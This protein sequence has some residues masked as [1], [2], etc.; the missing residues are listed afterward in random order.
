[1]SKQKTTNK[2]QSLSPENYIRQRSKNLPVGECFINPGWEKNKMCQVVVTRKHV[3][4]N[5]TA[6]VYLAD[7][8]C[9]GVKD[10]MFKFNAPL[11]EVMELLER[12]GNQLISIPYELAH[13]IVYAAIEYAEE[14]GF[15]PHRDFTS[16]TSY[17]L[18]DDN[19]DIPLMEIECGMDGKP[20]YTNTG[21]D[22]PAREREVLAQLER[23]AGEG[24][25]YFMLPG[26]S[27]MYHDQ[28]FDDE[29]E[30]EDDDE[31]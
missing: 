22:S 16:I 29:Y 19:D 1:M 15:K 2:T 21:F 3:T 8:M 9:L 12:R 11:E 10:T 6:C 20:C 14:W 30:E 23:T 17:F 25:Y 28:D 13:N 5:V 31:M 26:S 7:L 4:G 27:D 18:E 24:N